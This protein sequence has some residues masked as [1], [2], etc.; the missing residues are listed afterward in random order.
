[1]VDFLLAKV[2]VPVIDKVFGQEIGLIDQE[3]ELF[4][5]MLSN[6]LFEVFRVEEVWVPGIHDL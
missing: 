2:L 5:L 3:E 1:M 6:I 4:A